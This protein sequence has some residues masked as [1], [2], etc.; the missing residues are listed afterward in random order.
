M[1][2][3]DLEQ[4]CLGIENSLSWGELMAAK[5]WIQEPI[6]AAMKRHSFAVQRSMTLQQT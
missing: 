6:C 5:V 2:K 1:E 4:Q 3:V